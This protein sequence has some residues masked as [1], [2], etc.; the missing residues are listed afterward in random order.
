MRQADLIPTSTTQQ[1]L[2]EIEKVYNNK[3]RTKTY[4]K[5]RYRECLEN[6]LPWYNARY[7]DRY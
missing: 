6:K 3:A 5:T 4:I 7:G 1:A 2:D